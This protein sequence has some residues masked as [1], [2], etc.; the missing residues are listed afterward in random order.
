MQH[1]L[2]NVINLQNILQNCN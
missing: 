2:L 1:N